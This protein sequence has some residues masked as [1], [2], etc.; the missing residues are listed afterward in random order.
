M[1]DK[2]NT[3]TPANPNRVNIYDATELGEYWVYYFE[4]SPQAIVDAVL[5]VGEEPLDVYQRLGKTH[6]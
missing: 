2:I 1:S 6:D 5:I 4:A 3:V